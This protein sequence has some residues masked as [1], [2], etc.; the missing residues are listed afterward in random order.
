MARG[1][2]RSVESRKSE[3]KSVNDSLKNKENKLT[4][5]ESTYD[6]AMNARMEVENME[7]LNSEV[8]S[9]LRSENADRLQD[10]KEQGE[11]L[12]DEMSDENK[13]LDDIRNENQEALAANREASSKMQGVGAL[14]EKFG[15]QSRAMDAL[16]RDEEAIQ[17][18]FEDLQESQQRHNE[19]SNRARNLGTLRRG[20]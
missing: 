6:K 2:M 11:K 15:I 16:K 3:I 7:N 9:E 19:L 17:S 10:L 12:S 4:E 5:L 13:K 1:N 20:G 14:M 8:K 18:V